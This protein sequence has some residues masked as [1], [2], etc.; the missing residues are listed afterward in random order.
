[1]SDS[2]TLAEPAAPFQWSG[3]PLTIVDLDGWAADIAQH[4]PVGSAR[5]I[6]AVQTSIVSH[7]LGRQWYADH[8]YLTSPKTSFLHPHF[9][10]DGLAPVWSMR[11][12]NLAEMLF[13]LQGVGGFRVCLDHMT[14]DQLESALSELQVGMM[15][16]QSRIAF[17]YIDPATMT[18][19]SPDIEITLE[20][21]SSA[22]ADIKCKY[23]ETDV[24]EETVRNTLKKGL[25]QLPSGRPGLIFVKVPHAWTFEAGETVMLPGS[26]IRATNA[27]LRNTSRV[28]KVVYYLFHLK[29]AAEGVRNRNAIHEINNLRNPPESQWNRDLFPP[30]RKGFNWIT[31]P[32]LL[33][34]WAGLKQV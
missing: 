8:A 14:L 29:Q 6:N 27:F 3:D 20:D 2:T 23:E 15:L 31:T 26:V 33:E 30:G 22:L 10:S 11:M 7:F 24:S 18:G 32:A 5:F 4:A 16:Y 12:L 34:R 13:N 28:A 17:R 9:G 19:K 1:M 21:G 25:S